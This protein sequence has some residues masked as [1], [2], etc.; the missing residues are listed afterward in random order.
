M[1]TGNDSLHVWYRLDNHYES[2]D[3]GDG[4]E[5]QAA[6]INDVLPDGVTCDEKV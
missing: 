4:R 6:A 1:D 2:E 3:I 5:R